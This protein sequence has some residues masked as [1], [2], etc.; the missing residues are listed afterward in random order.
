MKYIILTLALLTAGLSS[1]QIPV[2]L[3]A[4]SRWHI[5]GDSSLYAGGRATFALG[6]EI[7]GQQAFVQPELGISQ[8]TLEP[9]V[10]V[11]LVLDAAYETIA[12]DCRATET[13]QY[14][15]LELRFG[16]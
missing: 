1:A 13:Q 14:C 16:F 12:L 6:R 2:D 15:G 9:Y 8:E 7:W 4:G 11:Q 5:S 3:V 10:R